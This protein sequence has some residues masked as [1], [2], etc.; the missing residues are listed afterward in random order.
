[1]WI[2]MEEEERE[3]SLEE[4]FSGTDL[5]TLHGCF[6]LND[7]S[8]GTFIRS[9]FF[10]KTEVNNPHDITNMEYGDC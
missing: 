10:L 7:L 8:M 2:D 9:L 6:L 4:I 5:L 1:M 3:P